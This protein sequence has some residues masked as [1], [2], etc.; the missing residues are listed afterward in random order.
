MAAFRIRRLYYIEKL[1]HQLTIYYVKCWLYPHIMKIG[2]EFISK[3]RYLTLTRLHAAILS[4]LLDKK[5]TLLDNSYSK[6][7]NFHKKWLSNV[8]SINFVE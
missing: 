4:I 5:F 6:N 7:K 8:D 1:I 3:Y 2:I